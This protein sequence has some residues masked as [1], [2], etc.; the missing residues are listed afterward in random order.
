MNAWLNQH[1][2]AL[3]LALRRL[4]TAPVNT[5]LS[6][7]AIGIALALPV[8][9]LILFS[10]AQ[11]LVRGTS[12]LPQISLFMNLDADR[13]VATDTEARL[14]QNPAIESVRFLAREATLTSM[15]KSEGLSEVID[16]LPRNPF[17]DAFVI[18]PAH[19]DSDDMEHLAGEL[20][21]MQQVDHVQ[22]DSAWVRRLNA[23]LR[24]GRT[25]LMA[26]SLLLGVGLIAITFNTIRL[27]VIT[28]KNEIDVSRLLGATNAFISRPFFYLGV[29][30]GVL[31][32][33]VAWSIVA[34]I[35]LAVRAPVQELSALY[36]FDVTLTLPDAGVTAILLLAAGGLGWLGTLL[37]LSQ[38]LR[39]S[40]IL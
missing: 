18:T 38:Y 28:L 34:G 13:K 31:G 17:P 7:L 39:R 19:T 10:N 4:L 40:T 12:T 23:M 20:R 29:L 9:G 36:G 25:V 1:R 8:G 30:Q 5:L 15:R 16:A 37:S 33:L 6:M 11:Q 32:G 3:R 27:Q 2:D 35:T 22:I 26:L 21:K 14:K 24:L